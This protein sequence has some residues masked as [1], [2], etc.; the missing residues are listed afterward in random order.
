MGEEVKQE[1]DLKE[2]K[3]A[4]TF[5]FKRWIR[6]KK[7]KGTSQNQRIKIEKKWLRKNV[8][9]TWKETS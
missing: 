6:K 7:K 5:T 2:K 3:G 1:D 4:N 9:K 8:G